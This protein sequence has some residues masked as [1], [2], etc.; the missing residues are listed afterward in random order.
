MISSQSVPLLAILAS[1]LT[2]TSLSLIK[3]ILYPN[4]AISISE[5]SVEF[6]IFFL[7]LQP[8]LFKF[9]CHQQTW[10]LQFT[11]L[12]HLTNK[13]Q[14][15]STHPKL[16]GTSHYKHFKIST[17][18]TNTQKTTL[19][20][21]QT[22]NWL[23]N[24]SSHIQNTYKSTTYI[25][26]QQSFISVTLCFYTI[27]WFT[28][29]FHSIRQIITWQKGFLCHRSP[30]L[31]F[32]PSWYPKHVF[33]TNFPFPAQNT[34]FQNCVPSL[35][36]F[37]SPWTVYPDFDSCYSHFMPYR[38][39]L[40]VRHRAIEVH[41]YYNYYYYPS[42]AHCNFFARPGQSTGSDASGL[43]QRTPRWGTKVS[44]QPVV[45]RPAGCSSFDSAAPLHQQCRKRNSHRAALAG[46]FSEG[47]FQAVLARSSVSSWVGSALP[48]PVLHP[49]QLFHW[50]LTSPFGRN[51]HGVCA[52][53]ADVDN[54]TSGVCRLLSVCMEQSPGWSSWS[55]AQ[56]FDF[57]TSTQNS[58]V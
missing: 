43:L 17:Y 42:V 13:S 58:P 34:P 37:P 27:F 30:T 47:D 39:T 48:D 29:S 4:L 10:L 26:L 54:W 40:S 55:R 16:I 50:P 12:W 24:L 41:Y 53:I 44:P 25:P 46:C 22:K 19:A 15:T 2:L 36:S 56:S 57:Q 20:S 1:S 9:T 5:T 35:G 51:E 23:Q 8:Q 3:S 14:Q 52:W 38:M 18:H 45:S 32:T 11:L 6:V 21:Y 7:F 31:E 33:S 28:C 49:S